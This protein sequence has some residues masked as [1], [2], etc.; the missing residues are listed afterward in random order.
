MKSEEWIFI[1][2]V[3]LLVIGFP[4]FLWLFKRD[5]ERRKK[6]E[7]ERWKKPKV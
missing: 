4:L 7:M 1:V 3:G 2:F 6:E 5:E